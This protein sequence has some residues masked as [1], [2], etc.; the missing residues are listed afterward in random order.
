VG[1]LS[2][3]SPMRGIFTGYN[4][5]ETAGAKIFRQHQAASCL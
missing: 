1:L 4:Y 3:K 2:A 5:R